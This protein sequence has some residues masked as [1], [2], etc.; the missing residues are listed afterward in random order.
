MRHIIL[1]R[2]G[3]YNLSGKTDEE[4]VLTAL[5][6]HDFMVYIFDSYHY[7]VCLGYVTI[8][9]NPKTLHIDRIKISHR[10][11]RQQPSNVLVISCPRRANIRHFRR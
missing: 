3:Q 9:Q 1:I 7:F 6:T 5:G 11:N 10:V 8:A 4:K 2:H